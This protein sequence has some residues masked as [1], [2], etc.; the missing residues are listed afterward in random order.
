MA[1]L[2]AGWGDSFEKEEF[3]VGQ[4][5][6]PRLMRIRCFWGA[7]GGK[8]HNESWNIGLKI[9]RK[10]SMTQSVSRKKMTGYQG[11]SLKRSFRPT[12]MFLMSQKKR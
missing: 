7:S 8:L 5:P 2:G 4:K 9:Q 10:N 3:S 6:P 12:E 1:R 11:S